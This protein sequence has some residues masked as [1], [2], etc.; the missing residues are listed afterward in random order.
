LT[1]SAADAP[2]VARHG[3]WARVFWTNARFAPQTMLWFL[4]PEFVLG[5]V[6]V[7][8]FTQMVFFAFVAHLAGEG[9]A[10]V[11][12]VVV[13]NAVASV[14]MAS[15]FTVSRTTETEKNQGTIEPLLASPAGRGAL[16]LGRA[17]I[18]IAISL[19]T[20]LVALGYAVFVFGVPIPLPAIPSILVSVA[21]TA[22]AMVGFGLLL[23]GVALFLRT[24]LILGNIFLFLGLL[25][26]GANFPLSDLPAPAVWIG[27]ALPLTWGIAA[28]RAAAS[29]AGWVEMAPL[30]GYVALGGAASY[31]AALALWGAFERRALRTG[32]IVRF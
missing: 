13:G 30:W 19:V 25:L 24:S 16:Y 14:T 12:Y 18:P 10:G 22:V 26:S 4:R 29:G 21:L 17:V 20:V 31:A 7:A 6:A 32:S 3:S 23:G 28:V 11:A 1:A 5:M 2:P 9:T 27:D 15:V 8:P